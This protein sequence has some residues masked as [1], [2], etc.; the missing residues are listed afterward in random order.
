MRQCSGRRNLA[1]TN[2]EN[3]MNSIIRITTVSGTTG[4]RR[5][6]YFKAGWTDNNVPLVGPK[7]R[8]LV[9]SEDTANTIVNNIRERMARG[10]VF[11]GR[12]QTSIVAIE[13][14]PA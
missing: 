11:T 5:V 12:G 3:D 9:F 14:V 10:P 13:A 6:G 7:S 2:T 1:L 4:N 8:T